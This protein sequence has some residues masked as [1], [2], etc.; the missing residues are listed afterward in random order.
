M[1][2]L[3]NKGWLCLTI[4]YK[5]TVPFDNIDSLILTLTGLQYYYTEKTG[6]QGTAMPTGL[7]SALEFSTHSQKLQ[8]ENHI[9]N[10]TYIVN[11][12]KS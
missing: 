7:H 5:S 11:A 3:L 1:K 9:L 4:L 8:D 12:C 10:I 6:I 2:W